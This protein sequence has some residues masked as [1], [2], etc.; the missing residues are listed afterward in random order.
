MINE[1]AQL[2]LNEITAIYSQSIAE[3]SI[4]QAEID[5]EQAGLA[6]ALSRV[7]TQ[8]ALVQKEKDALNRISALPQGMISEQ[9]LFQTKLACDK[10]S[11]ELETSHSEVNRQKALIYKLEKSLLPKEKD[12]DFL[13]SKTKI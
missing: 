2:A 3:E 5:I 11:A 12:R 7:K 10:Q 9:V 1:D 6:A 4:I 13:N 8:E